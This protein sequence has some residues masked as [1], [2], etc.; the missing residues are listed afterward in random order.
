MHEAVLTFTPRTL[1]AT[2]RFDLLSDNDSLNTEPATTPISSKKPKVEERKVTLSKNDVAKWAGGDAEYKK[3]M[4]GL[5]K[6]K[7]WTGSF[8][9]RKNLR[10]VRLFSRIRV[11]KSTMRVSEDAYVDITLQDFLWW[12]QYGPDLGKSIVWNKESHGPN[13]DVGYKKAQLEYFVDCVVEDRYDKQSLLDYEQLAGKKA[14]AVW[15]GDLVRSVIDKAW[16]LQRSGSLEN[17][18]SRANIL[19][20][21]AVLQAR[22]MVLDNEKAELTGEEGESSGGGSA[23][24]LSSTT[25]SSRLKRKRDKTVQEALPKK[26]SRGYY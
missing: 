11:D 19:D 21:S 10:L 23:R 24:Q 4:E 8:E 2:N 5:R 25:R 3:A 17:I 13:R 15:S 12:V 22:K 26:K 16:E 14:A 18:D 7:L 9:S 20:R 1:K 6:A